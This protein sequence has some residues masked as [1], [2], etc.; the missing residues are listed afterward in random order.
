MTVHDVLEALSRMGGGHDAH[1]LALWLVRA[2]KPSGFRDAPIGVVE[3][4]RARRALNAVWRAL[5]EAERANPQ[6]FRLVVGGD[7]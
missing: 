2:G 7:P 6:P 5:D 3:L 1:R 4:R